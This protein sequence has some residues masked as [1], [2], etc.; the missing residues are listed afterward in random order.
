MYVSIQMCCESEK[1]LTFP[2]YV[3]CIPGPSKVRQT[4]V[5]QGVRKQTY[6]G[7]YSRKEGTTKT[8]GKV[9]V[10]SNKVA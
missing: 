2:M 7:I 6:K 5:S 1:R 10:Y 4:H 9:R 8:V 3:I